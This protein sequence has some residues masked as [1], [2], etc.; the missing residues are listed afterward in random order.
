M[1]NTFYTSKDLF[2][3]LLKEKQCALQKTEC[4]RTCKDCPC[5][6]DESE[7]RGLYDQLIN[8]IRARDP[9]L[10]FVDELEH[11]KDLV[12]RKEK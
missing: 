1:G 12:R 4:N 5:F 6:T 2:T 7:A 3:F 10:Y 11:I 8:I 9:E